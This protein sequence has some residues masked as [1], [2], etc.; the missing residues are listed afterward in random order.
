MKKSSVITLLC[1]AL[2]TVFIFACDNEHLA[3][4]KISLSDS[5]QTITQKFLS[6]ISDDINTCFY[7]P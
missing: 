2:L 5:V 4:T 7:Q 1:T 6:E 3:N